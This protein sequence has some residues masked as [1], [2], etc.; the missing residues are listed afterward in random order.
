MG[1]PRSKVCVRACVR[2]CVR[3]CVCVCVCACECVH[4]SACVCPSPSCLPLLLSS[5]AG[6]QV[7]CPRLSV[8]NGE[9]IASRALNTNARLGCN[10]GYL[11]STGDP[12]LCTLSKTTNETAKAVWV[13]NQTCEGEA[14]VWMTQQTLSS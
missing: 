1:V 7:T 9:V 3:V 5:C 6:N 12:L 8:P 13:G 4:A 2:A 10:V 11:V 14:M